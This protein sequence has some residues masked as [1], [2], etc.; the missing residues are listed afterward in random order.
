[1]NCARMCLHTHS[2]MPP[3]L[4]LTD[5][6]GSCPPSVCITVPPQLC[7]ICVCVLG[8]RLCLYGRCYLNSSSMTL[9]IVHWMRTQRWEVVRHYKVAV[10][11]LLRAEPAV[12]NDAGFVTADVAT[13]NTWLGEGPHHMCALLSCRRLPPAIA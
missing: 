1:M 4:H 3:V 2:N 5:R 8:M 10:S 12:L 7:N 6:H 11:Y 9:Q 13:C